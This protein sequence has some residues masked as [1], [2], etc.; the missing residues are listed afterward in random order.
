M[1]RIGVVMAAAALA[2]AGAAWAQQSEENTFVSIANQQQSDQREITQHNIDQA[3]KAL[4]AKDYKTA[5]KYAQPV[6][7]ADPKRV[8]AWLLLGTA[9]IGLGDYRAARTAY[10]TAVRLSPVDPEARAG[11]AIAYARTK[12][13]KAAAQLAWLNEKIA[14]C[15]GR[16]PQ[17]TQLT[18]LKTDVE[19]ALAE[20]AKAG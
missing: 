13:P 10:T 15:A 4:R 8:E 2:W 12:D 18:R 17:A 1:R 19:T 7:R 14:A 5:R 3:T 11:L 16:C 6:T 9:Q 20:A